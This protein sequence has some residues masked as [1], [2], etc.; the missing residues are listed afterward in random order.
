MSIRKPLERR[1]STGK[2]LTHNT[3]NCFTMKN[4]AKK[5]SGDNA[6]LTKKSFR[7]NQSV[8]QAQA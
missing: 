8:E 4:Q 2:N 5:A 3:D 1:D 7:R 6:T